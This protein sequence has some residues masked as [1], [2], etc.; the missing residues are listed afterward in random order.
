VDGFYYG[1]NVRPLGPAS[2]VNIDLSEA[3][4]DCNMSKVDGMD[5]IA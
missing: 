4:F 1:A 3:A 5:G 2:T